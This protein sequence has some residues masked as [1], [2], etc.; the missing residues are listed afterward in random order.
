[1]IIVLSFRL[2][3]ASSLFAVHWGAEMFWLGRSCKRLAPSPC[4]FE[5]RCVEELLPN[6]VWGSSRLGYS[7]SLSMIKP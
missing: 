4:R 1:M 2:R 6:G 3:C 5:V 7:G